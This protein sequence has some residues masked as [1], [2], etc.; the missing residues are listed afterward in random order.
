MPDKRIS[1]LDELYVLSDDALLPVQSGSTAYHTTG[2]TWKQFVRDAI[3]A[4]VDAV[5]R[6]ASRSDD[7]AAIAATAAET[8]SSDRNAIQNMGVSSVVLQPGD[9]PTL[10]RTVDQYGIWNLIFGLVPGPKGDTGRAGSDGIQG[11]P[12]PQG[13]PASAGSIQAAT[14]LFTFSIGESTEQATLGEPGHLLLTYAGNETSA[15]QWYID[16]TEGD[17]YGHLM[18]NPDAT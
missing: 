7:N 13:A 16:W 6:A 3:A 8:A 12:G 9:T 10:T 11:P 17:T 15:N 18:F 14:G 1:D 5:M 4:E 2:A